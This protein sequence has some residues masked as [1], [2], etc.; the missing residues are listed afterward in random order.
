MSMT[1]GLFSPHEL[2]TMSCPRLNPA[3]VSPH[4]VD[5]AAWRLLAGTSRGVYSTRPAAKTNELE[6]LKT[7]QMAPSL[8]T[9][10]RPVFLLSTTI[11]HKAD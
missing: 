6:A 2:S 4:T 5:S 8:S 3:P 10:V 7:L 9:G 1:G 11:V